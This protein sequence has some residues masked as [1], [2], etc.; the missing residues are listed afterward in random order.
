VRAV[1]QFLF[2]S[3]GHLFSDQRSKVT[4]IK[5]QQARSP[6]N[7]AKSGDLPAATVAPGITQQE[8]AAFRAFVRAR[9]PVLMLLSRQPGDQLSAQFSEHP[10]H[11]DKDQKENDD[12]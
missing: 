9:N 12:L 6:F 7:F 5:R 4:R 11:E 8:L 3:S 10:K 2:P 1:L